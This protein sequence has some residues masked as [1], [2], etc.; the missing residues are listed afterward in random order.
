SKSHL[1]RARP[2][3]VAEISA[4]I[5]FGPRHESRRFGQIKLLASWSCPDRERERISSQRKRAFRKIGEYAIDS[6]VAHSRQIGW[7][8]DGVGENKF[9][10]FV[11]ARNYLRRDVF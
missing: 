8:V 6:E 1:D 11:D 4:E 3:R 2:S 10:Q 9:A 7:F 5:P